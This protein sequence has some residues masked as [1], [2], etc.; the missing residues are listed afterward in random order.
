MKSGSRKTYL[1]QRLKMPP[2]R[3]YSNFGSLLGSMGGS[4][5][6]VFDVFLSFGPSWGQNGSRT[7]PGQSQ[8]RIFYDFPAIVSIILDNVKAEQQK[9]ETQ[10]RPAFRDIFQALLAR[11]AQAEYRFLN[12]LGTRQFR[13][14]A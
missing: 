3:F 13:L 7:V 8:A 11:K 9:R 2:G 10:K 4:S 6:C 12:D 1:K 14:K 5:S